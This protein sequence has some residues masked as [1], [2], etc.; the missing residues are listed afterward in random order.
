MSGNSLTIRDNNKR[1]LLEIKGNRCIVSRFI[2]M[3][4]KTKEHLIELFTELTANDDIKIRKFL[5][6]ESEE[7]EFCS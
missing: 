6:F 1:I 3:N 7:Q 5:D 4:E 2:D